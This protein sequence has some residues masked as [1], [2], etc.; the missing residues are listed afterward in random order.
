MGSSSRVQSKTVKRLPVAVRFVALVISVCSYGFSAY[1]S[2]VRAP[3]M[4]FLALYALV[5][6][7]LLSFAAGIFLCGSLGTVFWP[8]TIGAAVFAILFTL[9][10]FSFD[11]SR[12]H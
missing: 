1:L 12:L 3:N 5:P 11:L 7:F 6:A 10:T 4:W 9:L 8:A 2:I